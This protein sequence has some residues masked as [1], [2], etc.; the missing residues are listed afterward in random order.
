MLILKIDKYG[1]YVIIVNGDDKMTKKVKQKS[2]L[3]PFIGLG[4]FITYFILSEIEGLPFQL[5]NIDTSQMPT[6]IKIVYM[7]N[8]I[9][10]TAY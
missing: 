2:W 9:S 6:W 4:A 1:K 5:L 7:I 10:G 3:L 8:K